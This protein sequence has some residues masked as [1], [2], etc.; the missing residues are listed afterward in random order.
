MRLLIVLF[1]GFLL[2]IIQSIIF[3]KYWLKGLD[4]KIDFEKPIIREGDK[5][6]LIETI[7]NDKALFLPVLLLKFSITRTFVFPKESNSTVTDLYY[8]S[9]YFTCNPYQ[10]ITRKYNFK[11]TKRGEYRISSIDIISKD[12]FLNKN[13]FATSL[14]DSSVLVLPSRIRNED[15][16]DN[17]FRFTGEVVKK[18][19]LNEDPFEFRSIRDYQPY[20]SMNHINW[21]SSAKNEFLKVNTFNTTDR[22][23]VVI[24]LNLDMNSLRS[25]D[26]LSEGSIRIASSLADLFIAEQIPVSLYTNGTDY[27]SKEAISVHSGCDKGHIANIDIAL[28]RISLKNKYKSFIKL[29]EEKVVEDK[30]VE[31]L[32]ISNYRKE[33]LMSKLEKYSKEG[34]NIYH[35]VPELDGAHVNTN[36][37]TF[38]W[39]IDGEN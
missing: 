8:R 30:D 9:D 15:I 21:K 36:S 20:D 16:P 1:I 38:K 13:T 11:A 2:Y 18:I 37:N 26:A 14:S 23:N 5:N 31:Y 28:A 19:K 39:V 17:I 34:L 35:I 4:V 27:D 10:L 7:R 33:D 22:K 6:A 32:I 24:L 12:I 29:V 25:T 3:K